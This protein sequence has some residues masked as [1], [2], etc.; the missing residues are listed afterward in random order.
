MP[1][2]ELTERQQVPCCRQHSE[3]RRKSD[4]MEVELIRVRDSVKRHPNERLE[5]Q[6]L[7]EKC[8]VLDGRHLNQMRIVDRE[9]HDGNEDDEAGD[10]ARD[11]DVEQHLAV[12]ERLPD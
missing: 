12:W 9:G 11:G 3:P 4:R 2:V 10:R 8:A 6:W 7:P 5:E 1:A